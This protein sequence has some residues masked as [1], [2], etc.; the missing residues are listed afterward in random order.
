MDLAVSRDYCNR[1]KISKRKSI[2]YTGF[3]TGSANVQPF[4]S[5]GAGALV[6]FCRRSPDLTE[7]T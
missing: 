5:V 6:V 2:Q 7:W 3:E 1:L 4:S